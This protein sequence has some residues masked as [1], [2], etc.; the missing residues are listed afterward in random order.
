MN[1]SEI[2]G[3]ARTLLACAG[4]I[5]VARGYLDNATMVALSGALVTIGTGAWSII[6]KR[7]AKAATAAPKA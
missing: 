5:L 4:G 7:K 6:S 1:E 3:I 2:G